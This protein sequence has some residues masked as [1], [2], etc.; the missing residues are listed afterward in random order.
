[1]SVEI[2]SDWTG[3]RRERIGMPL[4]VKVRACDREPTL[5]PTAGDKGGAPPR[6][7]GSRICEMK[8]W[9][10][11]HF[12]VFNPSTGLFGLVGHSVWDYLI[13]KL[14]FHRSAALDPGC[15]YEDGPNSCT[16]L[17]FDLV[18]SERAIDSIGRL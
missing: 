14:F 9:T 12:D 16:L 7:Y 4:R 5:S 6:L 17:P 8:G 11:R 2:E 10:T 18:S 1:M 15:R 13:G 3:R